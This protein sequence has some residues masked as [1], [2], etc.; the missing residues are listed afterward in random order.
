M[1][2][3]GSVEIARL[4]KKKKEDEQFGSFDKFQFGTSAMVASDFHGLGGYRTLEYEGQVPTQPYNCC[5]SR[6]FQAF[7][8]IAAYGMSMPSLSTESTDTVTG[9][10]RPRVSH[11]PSLVTEFY[12]V[13]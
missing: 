6:V 10:S 1:S 12:T 7:V 13:M 5:L 2:T 3:Y 9:K 11:T 4:K 8:C